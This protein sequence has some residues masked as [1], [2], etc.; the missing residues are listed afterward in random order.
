MS[1]S[2]KL[3]IAATGM[4]TPVGGDTQMTVA[5]VN[6]GINVYAE[7]TYVNREQYKMKLAQVP[8]DALPPLDKKIAQLKL[9]GR[10]NKMI[11]MAAT[12]LS[13]IFELFEPS[14]PIPIFIAAP[15]SIPGATTP[16]N[17]SF[18][19]KIMQQS[20]ITFDTQN[21]AV[22]PYGRAS[23]AIALAKAFE[24]I[25]SAQADYAILLGVDSYVDANLLSILD[26][27]KRVLTEVST[28]SFA[29]GEAATALLLVGENKKANLPNILSTISLPSVA[30]EEGHR[31]SEQPLLGNGLS[32]AVSV[33]IKNSGLKNIE[34]IYSSMNGESFHNKEFGVMTIRNSACLSPDLEHQHPADCFGDI[35]AAI[36]PTLIALASSTKDN[37]SLVYASSE[38]AGRGAVCVKS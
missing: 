16:I 37:S 25:H 33:A 8:H 20:G 34:T 30:N 23:G 6:A 2:A 7:S 5:A 4:I 31:Y 10:E 28:D 9:S 13:Q 17:N 24:C 3:Y 11:V 15:E 29:P 21:S 32:Q 36:F 27:D 1:Q 35:G 38:Q 22:F 19:P 18:L 12:A 26:D 14:K